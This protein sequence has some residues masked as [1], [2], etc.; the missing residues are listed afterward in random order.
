[1]TERLH[2]LIDSILRI[3][4]YIIGNPENCVNQKA[5]M[6]ALLQELEIEDSE[7]FGEVCA[8]I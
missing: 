7:V 2:W 8:A 1:M 4:Y 6:A 3:N 5:E